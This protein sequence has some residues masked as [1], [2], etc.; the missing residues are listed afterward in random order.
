MLIK[1]SDDDDDDDD[2]DQRAT[3]FVLC[4]SLSIIKQLE[5]NHPK[6]VT[7]TLAF[8]QGSRYTSIAPGENR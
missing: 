5:K 3:A 1:K 8:F 7:K 6:T 4:T 2:G